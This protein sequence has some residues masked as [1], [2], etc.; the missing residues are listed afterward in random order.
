MR[1]SQWWSYL[2]GY[3][4]IEVEGERLEPFVNMAMARGIM[5]WDL[6]RESA[7][8]LSARVRISGF[9]GLRHIARRNRCRLRIRRRYGFPFF[10][11]RM[12][13]RKILMLGALFFIVL[14]YYLSSLV[15]F[16]EVTGNQ[17]I[18][19]DD[20]LRVAGREGLTPGTPG[21][22]IDRLRLEKVLAQEFP[23]AAFFSVEGQGTRITI[24]VVE[25]RLPP[26]DEYRGG[27]FHVV[28]ARDGVIEDVI[29]KVGEPRV[30]PG[31]K[32]RKGQVLISG[33][34]PAPTSLGSWYVSAQGVVRAR[35]RYTAYGESEILEHRQRKT[36]L[37]TLR[38]HL[39]AGGRDVILYGPR[40]DPYPLYELQQR[41]ARIRGWPTTVLWENIEE[42]EDYVV[43]HGEAGA[44]DLA[45]EQARAEIG[46]AVMPN[47]E[48]LVE[49]VDRVPLNDPNRVRV[50]VQVEVREEIGVRRGF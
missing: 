23:E 32:V 7:T 6:R 45:M 20:I 35:V 5:L 12:R 27:R 19:A 49:D 38:V 3:L 31:D 18:A 50:R 26:P 25:K 30:K 42:L 46:G 2:T 37:K 15:W 11:A 29:V 28:A 10:A 48:T 34:L 24:G 22:R 16:I 1:V 33:I 47:S 21:W 9:F 41:E 39:M 40:E 14:M 8:R 43:E 44:L 36:G 13:K 17:Q 4:S